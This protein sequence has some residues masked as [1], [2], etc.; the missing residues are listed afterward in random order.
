M[1]PGCGPVEVHTPYWIGGAMKTLMFLSATR[2]TA[3]RITRVSVLSGRCVPW[4]S[5]VPKGTIRTEDFLTPFL[6]SDM[7]ISPTSIFS[8]LPCFL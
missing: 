8:P 6:N 1:V 2:R 7:V 4:A 5:T 3:S